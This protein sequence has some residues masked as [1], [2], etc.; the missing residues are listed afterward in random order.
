MVFSLIGLNKSSPLHLA[1]AYDNDDAI[2]LLLA[3]PKIRCNGR[4]AAG[5]MPLH[6]AI[7]RGQLNAVSALIACPAVDANLTTKDGV[8]LLHMAGGV[9]MVELLLTRADLRVD[10]RGGNGETVLHKAVTAG[11]VDI[12]TLLVG[13]GR[14]DVNALDRCGWTPLHLAAQ[15]GMREIVEVLLEREDAQV[16]QKTPNVRSFVV[17][18]HFRS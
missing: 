6:L 14:V 7:E 17:A 1:A 10:T 3:F 4:N 5:R 15:F 16:A 18:F 2:R 13:S 8:T 11:K 12:V 9:R